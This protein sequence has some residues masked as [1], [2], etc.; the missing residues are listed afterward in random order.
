MERVPEPTRNLTTRYTYD[1]LGNP[2]TV[3]SPSGVVTKAT[4]DDAGNR[5]SSTDGLG[6]T[7][8]ATFDGAGNQL[9]ATDPTGRATRYDYD[10]AGR[11]VS[12]S[13]TNAA[14]EQQRKRTVDYDR[15]GNRIGVTDALGHTTTRTYDALDRLRSMTRPV[16]EGESTTRSYGYDAAGNVTRATDGNGHATVFT[17]NAWGLP[18]STVEPA[19]AQTPDAADR[20][21]TA[22]YGLNGRLA[23]LV[24]PG[25]VTVSNNYD[26]LGNLTKQ[27]GSGASAVTPDRTFTYDTA[28]RLTSVSAPGGTDEFEYDDRGNLVSATGP[29]GSSSYA[30]D[31]DGRQVSATTQAGTATF[32][33]DGAGRLASATDPLT[34][35]SVSYGYD[36]AGR[37]TSAGYG[38]GR[39]SRAFGYDGLGRLTSDEVTAP[40]G[41]VTASIAYGYDKADRLTSKTT[42][43]VAGAA[44][45]TYAY[46]RA[47]RLTS[48]DDGDGA[49][50]YGW[51]AAG[52]VVRD[53]AVEATFDARNRLVSKDGTSYAY[54]PRGTLTS[55]TSGGETTQV[56]FNAFDELAADGPTDYAYDGLGRLVSAGDAT[57]SYAGSGIAVTGDGTDSYTYTPGGDVLGVG[58]GDGSTSVAWTDQHTDLVGLFDPANG[59][60]AG[61]RTYGPFGQQTAGEGAEPGLGYQHQYTDPESGNVNMGVRWYQPDAGTFAS[62]DTTGLDPRDVGNANRYAYVGGDPLGRTDPTGRCFGVCTAI[63][64]GISLGT[65]AKAVGGATVVAGALVAAPHVA[66]RVESWRSDATTDPSPAPT[67]NHRPPRRSLKDWWNDTAGKW[68]KGT[69]RELWKG[70]RR[71]AGHV[72][73][74][75]EELLSSQGSGPNGRPPSNPGQNWTFSPG[76]DPDGRGAWLGDSG[77]GRAA[78]VAAAGRAYR[79]WLVVRRQRVIDDAMTS[80][81][82]PDSSKRPVVAPSV[83][84][85][86]EAAEGASPV[87][88]G[89]LTPTGD[90]D[91]PYQPQQQPGGAAEP[92]GVQ[93]SHL[94]GE[95]CAA[96]GQVRR[97]GTG[98]ECTALEGGDTAEP[99]TISGSQGDQP[100]GFHTD[101][102]AVNAGRVAG[103]ARSTDQVLDSFRGLGPGRNSH[104]RTVGSKGELQMT[105]DS[106]I[107]GA[108]RLPARGPS[109]PNVYRLPDGGTFQWRTS[110][111][112]G[113][114]SIDIFPVKGRQRT[115][116][117]QDGATW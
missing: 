12:A 18:E 98:W 96:G 95:E 117:L 71:W 51:D 37:V 99:G 102:G 113:G 90:G 80:H 9:T 100:Y 91:E 49:H 60:L 26:P 34:G 104:V 56:Q 88:L 108:E 111:R 74:Q 1:E 93:S 85:A 77:G 65:A 101:A 110:S 67:P 66:D 116:H 4:W 59:Q 55:R 78:A 41:T 29:S 50:A 84:R 63:G 68:W 30:W 73:D 45:N 89:V 28:G 20:T 76:A 64:I 105:F 25:G 103:P 27:V 107:V 43:G 87:R 16:A 61:S 53:G 62:R 32:G 13:D 52:N 21:Y 24:K 81:A 83:R 38:D 44:D 70:A 36:E 69:G 31:D 75:F 15:A 2:A 109:V 11:R 6:N 57:L 42:T 33:Y 22:V 35:T 10:L 86:I 47:G 23:R 5:L 97:N 54:T 3:T 94:L 106:W 39:A 40:D 72:G 17:V 14:G 79:A 58:S 82:L 19:T 115:V 112:T 48:F 7:T 8:T 46:D 114:P 92:D